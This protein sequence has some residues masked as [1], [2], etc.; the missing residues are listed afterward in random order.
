MIAYRHG[1]YPRTS[2]FVDVGGTLACEIVLSDAGRDP[3]V[4]RSNGWWSE[5][6][7]TFRIARYPQQSLS[8]QSDSYSL[9]KQIGYCDPK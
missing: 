7:T 1:T 5:S 3:R 2:A 9:R 6:R 8:S 4:R